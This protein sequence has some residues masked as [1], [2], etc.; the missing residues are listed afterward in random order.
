MVFCAECG[1]PG[2]GRFCT[3]CGTRLA[4]S[5]SSAASVSE[6]GGSQSGVSSPTTSPPLPARS[7]IRGVASSTIASGSVPAPSYQSTSG[8][9]STIATGGTPA[10][11][12]S[13]GLVQQQPLMAN[14]PLQESPTALFGS[15][16]YR[17][18]A[19]HHIAREIFLALDRSIQPV[20]TQMIEAG[21]MRRF[22]ELCGNAIP[23]YYESH[24]L[25]LYYMTIGAQCVGT[26]TLSWDGW[27]T[28]L[29]HKILSAPDTMYAQL[30]ASLRNL[31]IQLPWP[32]ARGDFP[33]YAY[34]DAAARELQFQ[35]TARNMAGA[36]L[37]G[38]YGAGQGALN[39]NQ[40]RNSAAGHLAGRTL[41]AGLFGT[42]LFN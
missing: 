30:G 26:N 29:A 40:Q 20:G 14:T 15:Q 39:F 42:G 1:T 22:R 5:S 4:D 9:S 33:P 28:F 31:N 18:E 34:P 6:T 16:G 11:P 12:I 3:E 17:L 10:S 7:N 36:A 13:G 32:L 8:T 38:G 23:P 27:N 24:V 25:P 37:G 19:F 41:M 35:Q 2:E 21:K